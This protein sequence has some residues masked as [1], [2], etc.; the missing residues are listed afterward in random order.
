MPNCLTVYGLVAKVTGAGICADEWRSR[1]EDRN[2]G[3]IVSV[4]KGEAA[5]ADRPEDGFDEVA[6][7]RTVQLC[8]GNLLIQ[9]GLLATP[10]QWRARREEHN[11]RLQR[12]DR[13]LKKNAK[14]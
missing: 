2:S 8:R 9:R 14:S 3:G 1:G 7:A 10:A 13:W 5:P 4:R 11:D 6:R 12:I